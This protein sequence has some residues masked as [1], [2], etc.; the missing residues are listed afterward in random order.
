MLDSNGNWLEKLVR[1]PADNRESKER[2]LIAQSVCCDSRCPA[3]NGIHL[4]GKFIKSG[5]ICLRLGSHKEVYSPDHRQQPNSH[6]LSQ[7][8]FSAVPIDDVSP[9]F[10]NNDPHSWMRQQGSRDPSFETLG[11]HPLPC[12]S[13]QLQVGFS[14]QPPVA[15][16]AEAL[17]RRRIWRATGR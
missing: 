17:I 7:T 10:R 4:H 13:Y 15:R 5:A 16:K 3:G 11:L 1:L 14:R 6:K 9:M 2:K 12:A 8:P